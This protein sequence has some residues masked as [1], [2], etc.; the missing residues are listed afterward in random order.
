M[1]V[2]PRAR[3]ACPP[4]SYGRPVVA[5]AYAVEPVVEPDVPSPAAYRAGM[6]LSLMGRSREALTI[7]QI[8]AQLGLPK[9]SVSNLLTSLG[10][11]DMVRRGP[12]GWHLAYRVLELSHSML[13]SASMV[14][15]FRRTVA[16][17]PLLSGET[18]L[19]AVLDGLDV[20]YVARNDGS[21]PV[22]FVNETGSRTPAVVT[23]LG[24]AMLAALEPDEL[25]ARL[26][27]VTRLPRP[28]E[29]SHR[30]T[31]ALRADLAAIRERGFSVDDEQG[32]T[33]VICLGVA[34]TVDPT[35]TAVSVTM[36]SRRATPEYRPRLVGELRTLALNL[37]RAD[38]L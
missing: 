38:Q 27:R 30:T 17:L 28:T 36:I 29:R 11:A 23:A 1:S 25:E 19:L 22:R 31:A 13:I 6:L 24:K 15:E 32:V 20:V 5:E 8:S 10:A 33:G 14:T 3:L 16:G 21:Q 26:D 9:S 35:P 18:T 37:F 4:T 12:R 2:D 7:T 34:V